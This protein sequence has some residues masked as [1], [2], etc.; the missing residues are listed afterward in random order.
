MKYNQAHNLGFP[1][2]WIVPIIGKN[3]LLL[4]QF[5]ITMGQIWDDKLSY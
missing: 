2:L 1:V 5:I 4:R 3:G